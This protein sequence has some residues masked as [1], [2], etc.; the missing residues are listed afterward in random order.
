MCA[1]LER[2]KSRCG[3]LLKTTEWSCGITSEGCY[4]GCSARLRRLGLDSHASAAVRCGSSHALAAA[5]LRWTTTTLS[6]L[7]EWNRWR[8]PC[9]RSLKAVDLV[10]WWCTM[11]PCRNYFSCL[12]KGLLWINM[13]FYPS[14]VQSS[15]SIAGYLKPESGKQQLYFYPNADDYKRMC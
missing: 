12:I 14:L 13:P 9:A 2:S 15:L 3:K 5:L 1:G 4:G 7:P 6:P 10:S 11:E 8:A